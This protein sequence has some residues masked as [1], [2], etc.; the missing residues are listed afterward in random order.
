M[1]ASK[2]LMPLVLVFFLAATLA[3]CGGGGGGGV[4]EDPPV[5]NCTYL[6][7]KVAAVVHE[8]NG[9]KVADVAIF[10]QTGGSIDATITTTNTGL[11]SFSG[12]IS[13]STMTLSGSPGGTPITFTVVWNGACTSASGTET[14]GGTVQVKL[15]NNVSSAYAAFP[16]SG[17][18]D[19]VD[20]PGPSQ[21]V[22]YEVEYTHN[23]NDSRFVFTMD[24]ANVGLKGVMSGSS[25]FFAE[26]G[27]SEVSISDGSV[28]G[29]ETDWQI[30]GTYQSFPLSDLENGGIAG[31]WKTQDTAAPPVPVIPDMS[32]IWENISF[33]DGSSGTMTLAQTAGMLSGTG[34]ST[35][36]YVVNNPFTSTITSGSVGPFDDVNN[37]VLVVSK[38]DSPISV[39]VDQAGTKVDCGIVTTT[40]NA[41]SN[42]IAISGTYNN[43]AELNPGICNITG[44]VITGSR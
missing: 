28:S 36:P 8:Y 25:I 17:I 37:N 13:G 1:K 41:M 22:I 30:N 14:G 40:I 27:T 29:G 18:R 42:G 15:A 39:Y 12:S 44:G 38:T 24:G 3:A 19:V 9:S 16:L 35:N 7:G 4:K 5:I 26:A 43:V 20:T 23:P 33:S 31:T 32:G 11:A 10:T 2:V 21:I 34:S 6:N